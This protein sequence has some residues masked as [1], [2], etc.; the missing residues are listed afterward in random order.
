MF[1]VQRESGMGPV[2][3]LGDYGQQF[4]HLREAAVPE[5]TESLF[6]RVWRW[7]NRRPLPAGL[8]AWVR[9]HPLF[10]A[11]RAAERRRFRADLNVPVGERDSKGDVS[12]PGDRLVP[13]RYDGFDVTAGEMLG[14]LE[15]LEEVNRALYVV[16]KGWVAQPYAL[17]AGK[18]VAIEELYCRFMGYLYAYR[19]TGDAAWEAKAGGCAALLRG[20]LFGKGHVLLQG[21]LVIDIP[22]AITAQA[23]F[24]WAAHT[25]ERAWVEAA[26]SVTDVLVLYHT[27]GSINHGIMPC[28][29][30]AEAYRVTGEVRYLQAALARVKRTAFRY[31]LSAGGWAGHEQFSWY[32]ANITTSLVSTYQALPFDLQYQSAKDRAAEAIV[33]AVNRLIGMQRADGSLRPARGD[34]VFDEL[35]RDWK[36]TPAAEV[37]RFEGGRFVPAPTGD[38]EFPMYAWE[39][40][41]LLTLTDD[42][43]MTH[44]AELVKGYASV[45]ARQEQVWRAEMQTMAAGIGLY[46]VKRL[47]EHPYEK[48]TTSAGRAAGPGV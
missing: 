45:V 11:R 3:E 32:H 1:V 24:L 30:L 19:A 43:G 42:L 23:L 12:V 7:H 29:A 28:V 35:Y 21:H 5:A 9:H 2:P 31:Q 4:H 27:S 17:Y 14:R 37:A 39:M 6:D 33:R 46:L 34:G 20:R 13:V 15:W 41:C 36:R 22:Y 10:Y 48:Y 16:G 44:V 47:A 26:L 40:L 25:G 38:G 8:N 18:G